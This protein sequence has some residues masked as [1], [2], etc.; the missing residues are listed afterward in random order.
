MKRREFITVSAAPQ[1]GRSRRER[2]SRVAMRAQKWPQQ[3]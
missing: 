3:T 2:S 1:H